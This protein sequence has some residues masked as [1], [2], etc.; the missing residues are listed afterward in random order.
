MEHPTTTD[1]LTEEIQDVLVESKVLMHELHS[2]KQTIVKA[3]I[4]ETIYQRA[5]DFIAAQFSSGSFFENLDEETAQQLKKLDDAKC[6][7]LARDVFNLEPTNE[8]DVFIKIWAEA[9]AHRLYP[10][11]TA[12]T[13]LE[14]QEKLE[15]IGTILKRMVD[16]EA[17]QNNEYVSKYDHACWAVD[18]SIS[19]LYMQITGQEGIETIEVDETG[20]GISFYDSFF[21][22]ARDD[23]V[24]NLDMNLSQG[25]EAIAEMSKASIYISI[26]NGGLRLDNEPVTKQAQLKEIRAF[27]APIPKIIEQLENETTV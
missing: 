24:E 7:E 26:V 20:F 8:D 22:S 11:D 23:V 15:K 5:Q 10:D 4:G 3:A 12:L 21:E 25:M 6:A 1:M 27:L 17:M 19:E 18:D 2:A 9:I 13:I 16:E 14:D